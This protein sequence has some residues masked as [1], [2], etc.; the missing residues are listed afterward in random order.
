FGESSLLNPNYAGGA[1]PAPLTLPDP[2][3]SLLNGSSAAGAGLLGAG[4][5]GNA[6]DPSSQSTTPTFS[7]TLGINPDG[8]TTTL[9]PPTLVSPG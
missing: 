8:S 2:T 5:L 9:S 1:S 4:A 6:L 3:P 7:V